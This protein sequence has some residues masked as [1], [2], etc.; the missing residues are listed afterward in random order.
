LSTRA[1]AKFQK[2]TAFATSSSSFVMKSNPPSNVRRRRARL[3]AHA[4]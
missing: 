2:L 3:L 1:S 4:H